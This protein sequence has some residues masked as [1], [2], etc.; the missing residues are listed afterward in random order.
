[1]MEPPDSTGIKRILLK[2]RNGI[3]ASPLSPYL[4]FEVLY[5]QFLGGLIDSA[6]THYDS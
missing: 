5:V 6:R 4:A 3:P 1:M 2:R